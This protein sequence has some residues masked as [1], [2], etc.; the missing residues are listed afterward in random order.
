MSVYGGDLCAYS[1]LQE[2]VFLLRILFRGV[3]AAE[4]GVCAGVVPRDG[5]AGGLPACRGGGGDAL[6]RGR[7]AFDAG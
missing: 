2:Q 7:N 4:G 5:V 6:F 1:V 3:V